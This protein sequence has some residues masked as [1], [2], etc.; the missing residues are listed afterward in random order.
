M[1]MHNLLCNRI[2]VYVTH[3]ELGLLRDRS[4]PYERILRTFIDKVVAV[5]VG[6]SHSVVR[7]G[8]R[9]DPVCCT[10]TDPPTTIEGQDMLGHPHSV[11]FNNIFVLPPS[12]RIP[13]VPDWAE[14][15]EKG[16]I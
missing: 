9:Q 3:G 1:R 14:S 16:R 2:F 6:K 8:D 13:E 4:Q 7:I 15:A 12:F 10:R 11:R 5:N